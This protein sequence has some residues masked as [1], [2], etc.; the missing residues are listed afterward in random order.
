[1]RI[2]VGCD[3]VDFAEI[4]ESIDTFGDRYLQRI[5]TDDELATCTGPMRIARLAARFAAKEAVI[6]A[7][8]VVDDPTPLRDIEVV[9]NGPVPALRLSGG[10]AELARRQGWGEPSLS[11]SHAASQAMAVVMVLVD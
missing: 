11:M 9:L 7:L 4:A 2:A 10:M 6:K 3:L 1:M 5:F 8:G